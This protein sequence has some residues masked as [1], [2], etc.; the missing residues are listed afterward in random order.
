MMKIVSVSLLTLVLL[1]SGFLG[2]RSE[3]RQEEGGEPAEPQ[4]LVDGFYEIVRE[5]GPNDDLIVNENQ[6]RLVFR[7][8]GENV[9]KDIPPRFVVV[10]MEPG[11]R[12]ELASEPKFIPSDRGVQDI[13]VELVPEETAKVR[14]FT[15][16]HVGHR[17]AIVVNGELV[18]MPEIIQ[19]FESATLRIQ[20][21]SE[22]VAQSTLDYLRQRS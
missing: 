22:E 16:A 3:Q 1:C 17:V 12:L 13:H 9:P 20:C 19:P 7:P 2:C 18:S 15:E 14:A 5:G 8:K 4:G 6:R 10:P 11:L 21:A